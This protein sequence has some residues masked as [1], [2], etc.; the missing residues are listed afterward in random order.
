MD[1]EHAIVFFGIQLEKFLA[2]LVMDGE[3]TIVFYLK[4]AGFRNLAFLELVPIM[5][6]SLLH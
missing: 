2:C 6:T 1:G 5:F 4:S 3:H